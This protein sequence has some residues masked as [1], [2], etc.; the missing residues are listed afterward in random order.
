VERRAFKEKALGIRMSTRLEIKIDKVIDGVAYK[1]E[2]LERKLKESLGDV[3]EFVQDTLDLVYRSLGAEVDKVDYIGIRIFAS[4][5][6]QHGYA[7]KTGKRPIF[8]SMIVGYAGD[9]SDFRETLIHEFLHYLEW[10]EYA[11]EKKTMEIARGRNEY[12][13]A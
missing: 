9:V 12:G 11:V 4:D 13:N 5:K 3:F 2:Q 7:F 6:L 10:D 8:P 1:D